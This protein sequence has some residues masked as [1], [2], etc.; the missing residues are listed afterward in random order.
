MDK[1]DPTKWNPHTRRSMRVE[2]WA[3]ALLCGLGLWRT[4]HRLAVKWAGEPE[5]AS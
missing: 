1:T 4:A 3:L 5:A 2:N